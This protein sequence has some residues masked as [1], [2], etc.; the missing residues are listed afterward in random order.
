MERKRRSK[1]AASGTLEGV[2]IAD[3][4][5]EGQKLLVRGGKNELGEGGG[6]R[7]GVALTRGVLMG[8]EPVKQ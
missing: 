5:V 7:R 6:E 4:D 2:P 1:G 8:G 3:K